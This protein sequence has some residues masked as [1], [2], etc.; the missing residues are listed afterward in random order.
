MNVATGRTIYLIPKD[1]E[2]LS[3][4]Q[5]WEKINIDYRF[6]IIFQDSR[7][8]QMPWNVEFSAS[9]VLSHFST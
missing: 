4:K 2:M 5:S 7:H 1:C 9:H 3:M 8:S 6:I